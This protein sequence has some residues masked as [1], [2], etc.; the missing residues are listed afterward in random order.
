M[1]TPLGKNTAGID[2]L[3]LTNH[4][5]CHR[6]FTVLFE[7]VGDRALC[8]TGGRLEWV[9]NI[10]R[11]RGTATS[12]NPDA[13]PFGTY[14]TK[15]AAGPVSARSWRSYEKI[16][17][18]EQSTWASENRDRCDPFFQPSFTVRHLTVVDERNRYVLVSFMAF[19]RHACLL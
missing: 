4:Q 11:G 16:G 10:L 13:R 19:F 17:D 2:K 7:I 9:S 15:M 6:L 12:L 1:T 14:K 18:C 5:S 3:S 8:V